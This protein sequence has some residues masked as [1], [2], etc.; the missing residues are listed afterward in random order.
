MRVELVLVTEGKYR[1]RLGHKVECAVTTALCK[2]IHG[3]LMP[4]STEVF[5]SCVCKTRSTNE[6]VV[7]IYGE[8][9][10]SGLVDR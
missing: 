7:C 10:A 8:T 1:R 5:W 4:Y 9:A 3:R 2:Q 6:A